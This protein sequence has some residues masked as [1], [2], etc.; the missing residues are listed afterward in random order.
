MIRGIRDENSLYRDKRVI[1]EEMS[2]SEHCKCKSGCHSKRCA[3]FKAGESC[4]GNCGCIRCRNPLN[5]IDTEQFSLCVIQHIETYK[6]L[7]A[8]ALAQLYEL[9]CEHERVPLGVLLKEY[10]CPK[11]Q[12]TYWYS[13]CWKEVVQDSCTWHCDVC[14]ICQDW[15]VWHCEK[16][17][18]CTYGLSLPCE[19]CG[20]SIEQQRSDYLQ[21]LKELETKW[22]N[23]ARK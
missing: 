19:N 6:A 15:R 20:K 10:D 2:K 4:G 12:E 14:G 21:S 9:P 17:N 23:L 3:C 11:C 22:K 1:I 13:F 16:C 5:G 7:S 8:Q 18:K